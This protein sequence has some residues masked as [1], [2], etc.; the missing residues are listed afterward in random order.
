MLPAK[1]Q[2]N[3]KR[4]LFGHVVQTLIGQ[5]GM[6]ASQTYQDILG[7]RPAPKPHLRDSTRA[8]R[9][10]IGR[11]APTVPVK[12]LIPVLFQWAPV[13]TVHLLLKFSADGPARETVPVG[14]NV[15]F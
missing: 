2:K 10:P 14:P 9:S 8:R 15:L 7:R 4:P 3:I 11:I 13:R 6:S 5:D 12:Q 1:G